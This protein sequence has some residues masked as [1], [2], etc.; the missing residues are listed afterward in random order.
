[1]WKQLVLPCGF[2]RGEDYQSTHDYEANSEVCSIHGLHFLISYWNC[3]GS[4]SS[5]GVRNGR[6]YIADRS[7]CE[8]HSKPYRKGKSRSNLLS[9]L[10]GEVCFQRAPIQ[11]KLDQGTSKKESHLPSERSVVVVTHRSR[12]HH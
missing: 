11:R 7:P 2:G 8:S 6:L 10:G 1:M 5:W 3:C 9:L 4:Q 12:G